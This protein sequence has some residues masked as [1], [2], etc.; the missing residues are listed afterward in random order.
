MGKTVQFIRRVFG[1]Q[2]ILNRL[3]QTEEQLNKNLK[4]EQEILA[5]LK[6]NSTIEGSPWFI[7]K[8][9]SP[10]QGAVDYAFFYTLYRTLSSIKPENVLEFGLG[11]SS[12]MVHQY[13][14]YFGKQAVTVEHDPEWTAFFLQDFPDDYSVNIKYL[15]LEYIEVKGAKAL[16]YKDCRKSF[17]G[18]KFDLILVDGPFGHATETVYSRPQII[19]LVQDN[20]REDF[21]IIIDDYDRLGEKNTVKEVLDVFE[22]RHIP[23]VTREYASIKSHFLITTPRQK[24]LTTL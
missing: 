6:F 24:F 13:A 4:Y 19:E 1:T 15:D 16:T 7:H 2:K 17:E 9:V 5:A 23:V 14:R 10:G 20:L 18:Q 3:T 21:V 11:Q 8:S 12:K 22:T